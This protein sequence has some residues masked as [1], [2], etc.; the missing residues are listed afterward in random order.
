VRANTVFAFNLPN[1]VP[2][3]ATIPNNRIATSIGQNPNGAFQP[4]GGEKDQTGA[5]DMANN[6]QRRESLVS[7]MCTLTHWRS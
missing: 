6:V 2:N 3:K 5:K 7:M 1:R 4:V